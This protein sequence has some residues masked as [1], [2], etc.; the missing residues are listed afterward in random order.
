MGHV[1]WQ[2]RRNQDITPKKLNIKGRAEEGPAKEN[3]V[4]K[5]QKRVP[6]VIKPEE[7]FRGR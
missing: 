3:D 4:K 2:E 6:R 5:K 1:G 7:M